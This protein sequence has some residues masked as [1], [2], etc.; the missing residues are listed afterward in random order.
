MAPSALARRRSPH[1]LA[2]AVIT[3]L[4]LPLR[5]VNQAP[6]DVD[7]NR[8][9]SA[10]EGSR[11]RIG[12]R[13]GTDL[14]ARLVVARQDVVVITDIRT[15]PTGVRTKAGVSL[16]DGLTIA[17]ADVASIALISIP[18]T[19]ALPVTPASFDQLRVLVGAGQTIMITDLS[20]ARYAGTVISLS[21]SSLAV[22]VGNTVRQLRQEEV[23]TIRHRRADPLGNGALWGLGAG[24]G[25]GMATC[26]LC[27]IG[28]GAGVG[29]LFGGIGAGIGIG[30]DA[31]M[32]SD[33]VVF[34][35]PGASGLRISVAPR[36]A[37]SHKSVAVSIAF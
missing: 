30:L 17:R 36:L 8:V 6:T 12:L 16:K 24:F 25:T 11:V 37:K 31:L 23:A 19:R 22:R 32:R 14:T 5:A 28:R 21:S 15:G 26:G 3:C 34:R 7:W 9:V 29:L 1:L 27:H 35:G 18:R 10:P 2:L 20:G 13:D 33:V 4:T